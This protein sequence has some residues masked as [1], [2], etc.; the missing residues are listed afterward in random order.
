MPVT[1]HDEDWP[2]PSC[3]THPTGCPQPGETALSAPVVDRVLSR[4]GHD[5]AT[6]AA[7]RSAADPYANADAWRSEQTA[8]QRDAIRAR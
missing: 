3:R 2:G 1:N 4:A 6:K 7:A 5:A 8:A